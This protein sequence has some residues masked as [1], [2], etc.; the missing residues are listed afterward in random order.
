MMYVGDWK[1][2]MPIAAKIGIPDVECEWA[3][4]IFPYLHNGESAGPGD[5]RLCTGVLHCPSTKYEGSV[6]VAK[7]GYGWNWY[8]M[9]YYEANPMAQFQHQKLTDITRPGDS[10]LLGDTTDWYSGLW[11]L[12]Y[13][14]SPLHATHPVYTLYPPV[15]D[16]HGEGINLLWGDSHVAWM[17]Q[18][19]LMSGENGDPDWY[20]QRVK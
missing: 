1:N 18:T 15:G 20:F 5:L 9:G 10:L 3:R 14:Y 17:S 16:R 7:L 13:I 6:L 8:Y 12:A 19:A 2:R 11:Q 4:D